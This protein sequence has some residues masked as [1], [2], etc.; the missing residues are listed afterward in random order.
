MFVDPGCSGSASLTEP[1]L[2]QA[3]ND[4]R[5][6]TNPCATLVLD[7]EFGQHLNLMFFN[8][9]V[10]PQRHQVLFNYWDKKQLTKIKKSNNFLIEPIS[11]RYNPSI[12]SLLYSWH[13]LYLPAMSYCSH[14][15]HNQA[16]WTKIY[17]CTH[18]VDYSCKRVRHDWATKHSTACTHTHTYTQKKRE[19][20]NKQ[21]FFMQ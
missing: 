6:D 20:A 15:C 8:I 1:W 2:T 3:Q 5:V 7:S 12:F 4:E 11:S 10:L 9:N 18:M 19:W 17:L 16:Q 21:V 14:S 13:L